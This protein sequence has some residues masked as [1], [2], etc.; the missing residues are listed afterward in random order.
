M[1]KNLFRN[2]YDIIND[3]NARM[4]D[5]NDLSDSMIEE[6]IEEER[7]RRAEKDAPLGTDEDGTSDTDADG[8]SSGIGAE[9]VSDSENADDGSNVIKANPTQELENAKAEAEQILADSQTRADQIISDAKQN[10]ENEKQALYEET[11]RQAREDASADIEAAKDK[12]N[13]EFADKCSEL[14]NRYQDKFDEIE[15]QLVDTIT[16]V[17]EHVFNVD[18]TEYQDIVS[19]LVIE[20]M[21]STERCRNY[22]IHVSHDDFPTVAGNKKQLQDAAGGEDCTVDVIEDISL[23]KGQCLI[24]NAN[25]ILDCSIDTELKELRRRLKILSFRK[26]SADDRNS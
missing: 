17:Y 1:Y 19:Q 18:L 25:G 4:I 20:T 7:R 9:S 5:N 3:D 26:D 21:R 13:A 10:A 6:S 14:E 2:G 16:Q 12:N 23:S 8:F 11:C 22:M 24:E 15:P